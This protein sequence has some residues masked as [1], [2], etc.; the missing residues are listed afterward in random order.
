MGNQAQAVRGPS[1]RLPPGSVA[2]ALFLSEL[3]RV[4]V[5]AE[6]ALR[7]VAPKGASDPNGYRDAQRR[8]LTS[9]AQSI[10][11]LREF[12]RLG[13]DGYPI[14][15]EDVDTALKAISLILGSHSKKVAR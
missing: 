6:C 3:S 15:Y 5:L 8:W 10:D 13:F 7:N 9:F 4:E 14:E 11:S 2:W 12:R 1:A